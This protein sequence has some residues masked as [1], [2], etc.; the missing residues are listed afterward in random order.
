MNVFLN[1]VFQ[2]KTYLAAVLKRYPPLL[3][4]VGVCY[5]PLSWMIVTHPF[6]LSRG[7]LLYPN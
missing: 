4:G 2:H 5:K 7:D 6:P 3:R 1:Y